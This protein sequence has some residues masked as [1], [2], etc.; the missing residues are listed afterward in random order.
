MTSHL[1][2]LGRRNLLPRRGFRTTL[3]VVVLGL[4]V[5]L[6]GANCNREGG[7]P[8]PEAAADWADQERQLNRDEQDAMDM[9]AP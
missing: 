8:A 7:D 2:K 6:G 3:I 4:L 9:S 1:V 5:N